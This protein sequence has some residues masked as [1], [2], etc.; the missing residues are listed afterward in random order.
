VV[1]LA[2]PFL[3]FSAAPPT[4]V[5]I[6]AALQWAYRLSLVFAAYWL[7]MSVLGILGYL[8]LDSRALW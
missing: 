7:I 3:I 8:M 4:T 5:L 6:G 2:T 1:T